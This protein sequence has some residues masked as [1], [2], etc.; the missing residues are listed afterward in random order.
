MTNYISK[1]RRN[2]VMLYIDNAWYNHRYELMIT[3]LKKIRDISV[4]DDKTFVIEFNRILNCDNIADIMALY[5]YITYDIVLKY[6][7]LG[8]RWNYWNIIKYC[9][10]LTTQIIN[11]TI[12]NIPEN[13]YSLSIDGDQSVSRKEFIHRYIYECMYIITDT[14]DNY[15]ILD[16][17]KALQ[18]KDASQYKR[19]LSMYIS[20]IN[21]GSLK[22]CISF[23][24]DNMAMG[25]DWTIGTIYNLIKRSCKT[26]TNGEDPVV[27]YK[28]CMEF[29][30]RHV[31][32]IIN[33]IKQ[34]TYNINHPPNNVSFKN[35]HALIRF[36]HLFNN[37]KIPMSTNLI[38]QLH[39]F[40]IIHRKGCDM[41]YKYEHGYEFINNNILTIYN[42]LCWRWCEPSIEMLDILI[43]EKGFPI[44]D[45]HQPEDDY[46]ILYLLNNTFINYEV[47]DYLWTNYDVK[48]KLIY[49]LTR[50]Y[51]DHEFI[52]RDLCYR[53]I[54]NVKT[55]VVRLLT[56]LTTSILVQLLLDDAKMTYL[57]DIIAQEYPG[58][59]QTFYFNNKL[60]PFTIYTKFSFVFEK[61]FEECKDKETLF[62]LIKKYP[63]Y[64]FNYTLVFSNA[65]K[66]S[67]TSIGNSD[68]FYKSIL[69]T[70]EDIT[71]IEA[72]LKQFQDDF[73]TEYHSKTGG[74][75]SINFQFEAFRLYCLTERQQ[76]NRYWSIMYN[77]FSLIKLENLFNEYEYYDFIRY[78]ILERTLT[79]VS[80]EKLNQYYLEQYI[81]LIKKYKHVCIDRYGVDRTLY[82]GICFVGSDF[83]N[84]ELKTDFYVGMYRKHL[85]V[86]YIQNY[87]VKYIYYNPRTECGKR[88]LL[89]KY[90]KMLRDIE[91]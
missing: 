12:D 28:D 63:Y 90:N 36:C 55:I 3:Y 81:D 22:E 64:I 11:Y 76:N 42:T 9:K 35:I 44:Y 84:T 65:K 7:S 54:D 13:I 14:T 34:H 45:Y 5:R 39:E 91:D 20:R 87:F 69:I 58:N 79:M 89:D 46:H 51:K 37:S 47:F 49:Y 43:N 6:E 74:E 24:E 2:D 10:I 50:S 77:N 4:E 78:I 26:Y 21:F 18:Y 40:V 27:Y 59:V 29:F 85:K 53:V 31:I 72:I 16:Y 68:V 80:H 23:I 75:Y 56:Y 62:K 17:I 19:Q 30:E 70:K 38:I 88:H 1:S 83:N 82:M 86:F 73:A 25:F 61:V 60:V 32:F 15:G 57:L 33:Y 8:V 71:R 52:N 48:H 41:I 66:M 67:T